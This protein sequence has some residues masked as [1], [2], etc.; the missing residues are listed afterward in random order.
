MTQTMPRIPARPAA[1]GLPSLMLLSLLLL[2]ASPMDALARDPA[3]EG[4]QDP[5]AW[6]NAVHKANRGRGLAALNAVATVNSYGLNKAI[7]QAP[8]SLMDSLRGSGLRF[9]GVAPMLWSR[10]HYGSRVK[11]ESLSYE[12]AFLEAM[13]DYCQAQGWRSI[14]TSLGARACEDPGG[15]V[16]FLYLLEVFNE[17][18]SSF[19]KVVSGA[20]P[21]LMLK[22]AKLVG[23]QTPMER[24]TAAA[25]ANQRKRDAKAVAMRERQVQIDQAPD[26][27]KVGNKLCRMEGQFQVTGFVER[28]AAETD[29]VQIRVVNKHLPRDS[30]R[31]GFIRP[32]G[33]QPGIIWDDPD[34]WSLCR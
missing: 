23:Y 21:S 8:P 34:G 7:E 29:K 16:R 19:G 9:D 13:D 1:R 6:A 18:D 20:D 33:F 17:H 25:E 14:V 3:P 12:A 28:Y 22:A 32:G 26:R 31:D 27:R 2:S 15:N 11:D 10:G 5:I 30:S 4:Y 24:I